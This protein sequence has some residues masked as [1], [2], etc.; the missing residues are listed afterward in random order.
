MGTNVLKAFLNI[1]ENSDVSVD[2]YAQGGNRITSVGDGLEFY[3]KDAFAGVLGEK[4]SEN[5]KAKIYEKFFSYQG[6]NSRP[7][8][9]IIKNGDAIEVKKIEVKTNIQDISL[10]SSSPKTRITNK[11]SK[12]T[13]AVKDILSDNESKDLLYI[14]GAIEK[15]NLKNLFMVYGDCFVQNIEFYNSIFNDL[16]SKMKKISQE[17]PNVNA[18]ETKE[19]MRLNNI[20]LLGRTHLRVRAM[21]ILENP[22][23]IFEYLLKD[24]ISKNYICL[25]MREKKFEE[26][27]EEDKNKIDKYCSKIKI[28]DP[29]NE[30]KYIDVIFIKSE[31]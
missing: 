2:G 7:P 27:P 24:F 9:L 1:I 22:N 23:K 11:D 13:K 12:I 25:M 4:H 5:E 26:F 31:L 29:D 19:F 14:V 15:V 28:K 21:Y 18:S 30:N 20:D 16:K 8:D 17:I 10:N 6:S 3:V